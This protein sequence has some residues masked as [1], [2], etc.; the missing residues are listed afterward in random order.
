MPNLTQK[1]LAALDPGRR[2]ALLVVLAQARAH[3]L[4]TYLVGGSVRDLLL[5]RPFLD[6]DLTVE[7]DA[8]ALA[9]EAALALEAQVVVHRAFGTASVRGHDFQ[10][11]LATARRE[12]YPRPGALPQVEPADIGQD[13]ARRDFTIN[14]MA[15][16]LTGPRQGQLIDPF[17][18]QDDLAAG[19]LRVLH[20]AS[21]RD[22]AT[23]ILRAARYAA[24]FS[25]RLEGATEAWLRRDIAYLDTISGARLRHEFLRLLQE[26]RPEEALALLH[27]WGALARLHPSLQV[28]EALGGAFRRLRRLAPSHLLA[29]AYLA[30]LASP[31][32]EGASAFAARLALT[33]REREA[34]QAM[35]RALATL[36]L[37]Q[38]GRAR[39]SQ[40]VAA[41]EALPEPCLWALAALAPPLARARVLRY[42]G[43]WRHVRPALGAPQL[44]ALGVP[45]PRLREA[46][47]HLRAARLEGHVRTA[48][49]ERRLIRQWLGG[50]G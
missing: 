31:L 21:F 28:S 38:E 12:R 41:L 43:R 7:G 4:S 39:P 22:D 3:G 17:H 25:F 15:L 6:L 40:M 27:R 13:L 20:Q 35:P 16:A 49:G 50:S 48:R 23:R 10:L 37:L 2:R 14:A 19:Q 5:G 36:P 45:R 26:E 34:V 46:L 30:A 11:D 32:G 18:G 42:L 9:R 1:L 44:E 29:L 24:R 47:A 33:R 8:P